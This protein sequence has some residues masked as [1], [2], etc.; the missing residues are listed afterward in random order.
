MKVMV[1][2]GELIAVDPATGSRFR[3]NQLVGGILKLE[4]T[5]TKEFFD[6]PITGLGQTEFWVDP[7]PVPTYTFKYRLGKSPPQYPGPDDREGFE[8][9]CAGKHLDAESRRNHPNAGDEQ[10]A[11]LF[12]RDRYSARDKTVTVNRGD[13]C[14]FNI[15]CAGSAVAK[16]HLLRHTEDGSDATHVTDQGQRQT[17]LKT[18][19][20]DI[21]GTGRSFTQDG[22][23]VSYADVRGWHP[24][25]TALGTIEAVWDQNGAVCLDEPRR[26]KEEPGIRTSINAECA[27]RW[28][29]LG[30]A[31]PAGP[32]SCSA[33]GLNPSTWTT[34]PGARYGISVNPP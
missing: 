31:A 1:Q 16:M 24:L 29:G 9:L 10:V 34:N 26:E 6:V 25:P 2:R 28:P 3:G 19:T 33:L 8:S 15:A 21:C 12:G 17:M 18:I 32:P 22:E 11:V 5:S 27:K 14:W 30:C 4:S 20:D 23:D 13:E 7:A